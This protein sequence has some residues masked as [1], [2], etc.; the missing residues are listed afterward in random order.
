MG[1]CAD[2][3]VMFILMC[4]NSLDKHTIVIYSRLHNLFL[5]TRKLH[6]AP[7]TSPE[8]KVRSLKENVENY[9]TGT[10]YNQ[11]FFLQLLPNTVMHHFKVSLFHSLQD[12]PR[13]KMLS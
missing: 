3:C 8:C 1:L 7:L 9:L 11:V 13:I 6:R 2:T 5:F 12:V 4:K 10:L